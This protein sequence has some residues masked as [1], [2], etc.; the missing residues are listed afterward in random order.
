VGLRE[1]E[2][3]PGG[4]PAGGGPRP[5]GTRPGPLLPGDPGAPGIA[6]RLDHEQVARLQ[7]DAGNAAV[8]GLVAQRAGAPVVQRQTAAPLR[9]DTEADAQW[10]ETTNASV[11]RVQDAVALARQNLATDAAEALLAIRAVQAGYQGFETRYDQA[12]SN[13]TAGVAAAQA[14]E[15]EFRK[16]VAFAG[17]LLLAEVAPLLA[18]VK[19]AA[20]G[21]L[22]KLEIA[23]AVVNVLDA[24]KA[25][26]KA[27]APARRQRGTPGVDWEELLNT[28]VTAFETTL[29][30]NATLDAMSAR[31]TE[32]VRYLGR[33]RAGSG[34][35]TDPRTTPDGVRA[36]QTAANAA[37]IVR[38]LSQIGVG[39]VSRPARAFAVDAARRLEA[40]T[41]RRLE[42]DIGVRWISG[43]AAGQLDE[44]DT[45]EGYLQTIGVINADGN[46]LD[47]STGVVTTDVDEKLIQWLA[48]VEST[49]MELVGQTAQWL[50]GRA[51][52]GAVGGQIR[53]SRN[54]RWNASAPEGT[55]ES[56]GGAVRITSYWI[57]RSRGESSDWEW[58][59]PADL[60]LYLNGQVTFRV[61]PLGAT[62]G[63]ATAEGPVL[64]AP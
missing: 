10:A 57:N 18:A 61:T 35:A 55:S 6:D 12:V 44:I 30:Q 19:S 50:G 21:V 37:S 11:E 58:S 56:A 20:D 33:V 47:Y 48:R 41:V 53:D 28:T 27:D 24:D 38:T 63:G 31:C 46:R 1:H 17:N 51:L 23:A 32:H 54:R 64:H 3:H 22:G 36:E 45:A 25:G 40:V 8:S 59:H 4:A 42:Q 34:P 52:G 29:R 26:K 15:G 16:L 62:G 49:A 14:K 60:Q 13:F 5:V 9:S 39:E 7:R 2:R 43:L